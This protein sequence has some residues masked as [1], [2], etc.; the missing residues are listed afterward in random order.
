MRVHGGAKG[1]E[2]GIQLAARLHEVIAASVASGVY[3]SE[4]DA[5][6]AIAA[7]SKETVQVIEHVLDGSIVRPTDTCLQGFST[8]LGIPLQDLIDLAEEDQKAGKSVLGRFSFETGMLKAY[9]V[10]DEKGIAHKM[11]RGIA[12][13]DRIDRQGERFSSKA[14]QKM[15]DTAKQYLTLFSNH[16]HS[17][18]DTLGHVVG[19]EMANGS[20]KVECELESD[21]AEPR[22]EKLWNKLM[23]GTRLAF[24]IG[25]RVLHS[26]VEEVNGVQVRVLDDLELLELSVVGI[27]ANPRT[28]VEAIAKSLGGPPVAPAANGPKEVQSMT[29]K[30]IE[31]KLKELQAAHEAAISALRAELETASKAAVAQ[32]TADIE[33]GK[34]ALVAKESELSAIRA[35]MEKLAATVVAKDAELAGSQTEIAQLTKE[36]DGLL[37]QAL[38]MEKVQLDLS[39]KNGQLTSEF[40]RLTKAIDETKAAYDDLRA[41]YESMEQNPPANPAYAADIEAGKQ[42]RV[43][44]TNEAH[45]LS[46]LIEGDTFNSELTLAKLS[47][48]SIADLKSEVEILM[49]RVDEKFPPT[50][51]AA[52]RVIPDDTNAVEAR[53]KTARDIV[54]SDALLFP[55]RVRTDV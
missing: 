52:V 29:D 23:S 16:D 50:G 12:S 19:A 39:Q 55:E 14:V 1:I 15:V 5:I 53:L 3:A 22:V 44:L 49:K 36:R 17:W 6:V 8:V 30:E 25:G 46:G 4:S 26:F 13:D 10:T 7:S 20:F 31:A 33:A 34:A 28:F 32:V 37:D 48:L 40:D 21:T 27:P 43:S 18:E 45:R 47:A 41:K 35:D 54:G 51:L 24:S 2:K 9:L 11:I 38:A 42:Y